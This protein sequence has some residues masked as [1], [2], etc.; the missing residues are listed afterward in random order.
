MFVK[1]YASGTACR[2]P[3][4]YP[5]PLNSND[6]E[7]DVA[8]EET[9]VYTRH[10]QHGEG[11]HNGQWAGGAGEPEPAAGEESVEKIRQ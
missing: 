3:R 10:P 11:E 1:V 7:R 6:V 8:C 9:Q 5:Q 2:E 4:Y